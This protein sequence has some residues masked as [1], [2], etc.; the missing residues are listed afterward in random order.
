MNEFA[1]EYLAH[2]TSQLFELSQFIAQTSCS[3]DMTLLLGDLNTCDFEKGYKLLRHH[4]NL[5][6]AFKEK[7]D[8]SKNETSFF[9][10]CH[11][12]TNVYGQTSSAIRAAFPNGIRIDYI[13]YRFRNGIFSFN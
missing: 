8:A 12:K 3:A 13:L 6:D 9:E 11:S 4:T 2:R 7:P 5:L 1:D 10:T